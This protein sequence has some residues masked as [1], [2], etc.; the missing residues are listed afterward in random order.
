[1]IEP[2]F[3]DRKCMGGADQRMAAWKAMRRVRVLKSLVVTVEQQASACRGFQAAAINNRREW[4]FAFC[5][6]K[7]PLDY[8]KKFPDERSDRRPGS[9]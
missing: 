6:A 2:S 7:A 1:M 3:E 4:F 9:P 5:C 8:K